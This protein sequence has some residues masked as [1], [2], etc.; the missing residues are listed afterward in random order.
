MQIVVSYPPM[1]DEIDAKFRVKRRHG[2]IYSWGDTI[3][4]PSGVH[5]R[6]ELIAHEE[7]HGARQRNADLK[8]WWELYIES[9]SFRLAEE[10]PAHV[11]EL[12]YL[13]DHA[14]SR[15]LRRGALKY[16][17]QRFAAL[18]YGPMITVSKARRIL[19]KNTIP[20]QFSTIEET[21]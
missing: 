18:L 3:F 6:P 10:T 16:V 9:P 12:R 19:S 1:I 20:V 2:I 7:A 4:N 14:P 21:R 13:V 15:Q 17:A 11:A 5:I 8:A